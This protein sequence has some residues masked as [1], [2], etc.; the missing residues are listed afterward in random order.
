MIQEDG[1]LDRIGA[2]AARHAPA[3]AAVLLVAD[4]GLKASGITDRA[5][6]SLAAAGFA[7][8]VFDAFKSDPTT[9]STDAAADI[10]RAEKAALVVA[11]GGGSA[12]DL[13]KAVACIAPG[14]RPASDYA[15]CANPLPVRPLPK[16]CIPTT[17]G[18]GSETTR[19][20]VLT[21]P[22]GSKTWLWGDEMKAEEVVLDPTVTVGL[23]AHLTAATGIDAFV[24]AMEA[25]T[26]V[27]ATAAND[28][29]AH[30]AIGLVARHLLTAVQSPGDLKARA[31]L[32]LAAALAGVAI[33]NA[34]T[35]I[36]HNIGH[37]L[38]S[39]RPIHH[40]RAVGVAVLATLAWNAEQDPDG[41]FT[42]VASAMGEQGGAAA[43][44][45]AYERL[46]RASGVKVSLRG[47][48]FDDL[49]AEAL[50]AKMAAPENA[51]M[52]R[53]NAR[54]VTDDDLLVFARRVLEQE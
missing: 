9:S 36:G 16:I 20:S 53:S 14:S 28:V 30:A 4:P 15:L 42:A 32:Q 48:G 23:P 33:D 54:P 11:L 3:G 19:V 34:G 7:P 21:L 24:H 45:G 39:L 18:T 29:Y 41:R 35:A 27:N 47:E 43:L 10:A 5:V 1:A 51:P 50:A 49:T 2:L 17:S 25:S 44:A 12:L 22:D 40:G 37:A 26:N 52:R 8:L 6:A 31:G 46:L 13:G 38:A